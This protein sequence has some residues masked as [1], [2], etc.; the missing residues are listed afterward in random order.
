MKKNIA[1][2]ANRVIRR[3]D[4]TA[5]PDELDPEARF[6][7]VTLHL[8]S[9]GTLIQRTTRQETSARPTDLRAKL[10]QTIGS[11]THLD[12][13]QIADRCALRQEGDLRYLLGLLF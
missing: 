5:P 11:L 7:E 2:L 4:E 1:A 13:S 9:G 10:Q 6:H 12:S 3:A 8:R